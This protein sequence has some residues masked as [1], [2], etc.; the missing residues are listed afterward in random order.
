MV[1]STTRLRGLPALGGLRGAATAI[2]A[3]TPVHR[4][5]AID[6]LRALA[7]YAVP[8]G[9]WLLG[10]FTLDSAGALHNASPLTSFGF[11]APLSWVLQMLGIFFLVGGHASALSYRRAIARGESTAGGCGG[12]WP[13]SGGRCSG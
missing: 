13:G 10:G 7:L 11:F 3:R 9:H 1:A 2:D 8:M 4:D 12:G 6:G 5:R